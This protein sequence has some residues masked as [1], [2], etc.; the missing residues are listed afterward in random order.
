MKIL[1]AIDDS[2][3]SE[4]AVEEVL[5]L[6]WPE[7]SSIEVLTVI[8]PAH[9]WE[10]A[11]PVEAAHKRAKELVTNVVAGLYRGGLHVH[12]NVAQGDPKHVILDRADDIDPD[13]IVLGS[14]RSSAIADLF[15][16]NVAASTLRHAR[17]SVAIVRARQG[18]LAEARKILLCTDGSAHSEAAAR[19]IAARPWPVRSEVRVMSVV[20]VILPT[21]HALFEPPFVQSPEVQRLRED[22]MVRAQQAVAKAVSILAPTELTV[23]ESISVLLDGTKNVIVKEARDW[24]AD[25][26]FL[27]SHG[28]RGA[29]RFLMG[30]VSESV[31]AQAHCSVQVT[32]ERVTAPEA[33]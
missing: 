2:P 5:G 22:A 19:E 18:E 30:S 25:W 11:E 29:E 31:V 1:L 26:I 23:S 15:L 28:R 24:G 10:T 20:E 17:C 12:C 21:M 33:G 3:A 27:G 32:R 8:E 16:G 14:H 9:L 4:L 13:L 7:G 6:P